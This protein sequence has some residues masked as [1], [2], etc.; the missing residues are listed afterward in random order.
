MGLRARAE[1]VGERIREHDF[2]AAIG[3]HAT[4][5]LHVQRVEQWLARVRQREHE[6][7][8]GVGEPLRL[9]LHARADPRLELPDA[10][11]RAQP[12]GHGLGR[13]LQPC[14]HLGK[15]VFPVEAVTSR[16][17][18]V[19]GRERHHQRG[20]AAHDHRSDR[21]HLAPQMFARGRA[22]A[23]DRARASFTRRA[24]AQASSTR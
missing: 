3:Q 15:P 13:A 14:E 8:D 18:S 5:A 19:V 6:A 4:A 24:G 20:H 23:C 22:G 16:Q 10:G 12:L 17:Q 7:G 2:V 21:Q 11:D 1:G 9:Q